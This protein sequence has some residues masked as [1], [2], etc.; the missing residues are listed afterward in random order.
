M[1]R[2]HLFLCITAA[3]AASIAIFPCHSAAQDDALTR[4]AEFLAGASSAEEL[5]ESELE[6]LESLLSHKININTAS[7]ARLSESGLF[8]PLQVA[9]L[10]EYR[11]DS[12]D[13]L[14]VTE[15]SLIDG[16]T[17]ESA[18]RIAPFISMETR[19]SP[20]LSSADH[21]MRSEL[22]ANAGYKCPD[23][24]GNLLS[25]KG[26][27]RC[28]I[29]SSFAA[30]F[31]MKSSYGQEG[32]PESWS[33][34]A[35]WYGPGHISKVI[36]G[37]YNARFG[38]GLTFWSG[39]SMSGTV[40]AESFARRPTGLSP[41]C[42]CSTP[43]PNRGI[44]TELCFGRWTIYGAAA[45]PGLKERMEGDRTA[46]CGVIPMAVVTRLGRKSQYSAG[47]LLRYEGGIMQQAKAEADFRWCP[48]RTEW[49]GEISRDLINHCTGAIGGMVFTPRYEHKFA[50]SARWYPSGFSSAMAGAM[51]AGSKTA[52]ECGIAT[53]ASLPHFSLT[54]DAALFPS[55]GTGQVRIVLKTP[56]SAG[57]FSLTP[58]AK[59]R[60]KKAL[61]PYSDAVANGT[62]TELRL[63]GEWTPDRFI[64][65][66][67]GDAVHCESHSAQ[68]YAEAGYKDGKFS[69]YGR[70]GIFRADK[71]PD[72]IYVYE[73]DAPG[74][75]NIPAYYGRGASVSLTGSARW[76]KSR[77]YWRINRTRY[78]SDKPGRTEFKLQ[79]VLKI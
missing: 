48:G 55:K 74:N 46:Q 23:D 11:H 60:I 67:R 7:R 54:S 6:R 36:V 49:F 57:D 66:L 58:S 2:L 26:R 50:A 17:K 56:I 31:A 24:S 61:A 68:G 33:A 29:G 62:R 72:R 44:G 39:W 25:W 69:I 27:Y 42:T 65:H 75:F 35:V 12:G 30:G 28:E 22:Q 79:Y 64:L 78:V 63:D 21:R 45:F 76:R 5:D 4:A 10:C 20:G 38:Q 19:T 32:K 8:T 71:W 9:A 52:D 18:S 15:L 14:S 70:A 53:A 13:I 40:A 73:R 41:S 59:L 47:T 77:L 51:R 3:A 1:K 43:G 16:F 34:N 37:D